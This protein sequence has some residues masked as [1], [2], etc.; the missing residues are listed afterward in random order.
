MRNLLDFKDMALA[1]AL[2]FLLFLFVVG[3]VIFGGL[4]D[5]DIEIREQKKSYELESK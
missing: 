3:L 5:G 1:L 2:T 4:R